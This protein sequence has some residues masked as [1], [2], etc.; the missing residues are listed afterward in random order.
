[1][2]PGRRLPREIA[3]VAAATNERAAFGNK[4]DQM[5]SAHG[6]THPG[7]VRTAN[8][9]ALVV[10]PDLGLFVVADGMGG[11]NAGE[12]ASSM[13]IEAIHGFLSRSVD[14]REITWPFGLDGQLSF[15]ANRLL[16][17]V[18]LANRLV[19]DAG[20]SRGDY[21]GMGTTISAVLVEGDRMVVSSVGDSRVYSFAGGELTQLTRDD[22]W[23]ATLLAAA[24]ELGEGARVKHR[25]RHV[26]T[27]VVGAREDTEVQLVERQVGDGELL[28]LCSDGLHGGLDDESIR[29]ILSGQGDLKSMADLL[30]A[31]ALERD[32]SDNITVLLVRCEHETTAEA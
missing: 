13:A 16:T 20:G 5:I 22:S 28:L 6:I 7:R 26:L 3:I 1:V 18:K 8:E 29:S 30:L 27:N 4:A 15:A 2:A 19:F 12:V 14:D 21:A 25:M 32:G 17:G 11:H 31:T 9:D 23:A 24:P 10:D